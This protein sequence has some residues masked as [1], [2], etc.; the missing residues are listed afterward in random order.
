[1]VVPLP[2]WVNRDED[3]PYSVSSQS[4]AVSTLE[5][6]SACTNVCTVSFNINCDGENSVWTL[7]RRR[8]TN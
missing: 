1:M 8:V 3:D 4:I 7:Y 2:T 5:E 6:F